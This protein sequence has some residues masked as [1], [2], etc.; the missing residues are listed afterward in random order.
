[1]K[2]IKPIYVFGFLLIVLSLAAFSGQRERVDWR[3]T[4]S[5]DHKIAY[6]A[7]LLY[8]LL[9]SQF[10]ENSLMTARRSFT[11]MTQGN[12]QTGKNYL[13]ITDHLPFGP[14][15]TKRVM[16]HVQE[17][18]HVFASA[19]SFSEDFTDE[20]GFEASL[21]LESLTDT[22]VF[23]NLKELSKT[24]QDTTR[25]NL[26]NPAF[27]KSGGYLY[28]RG[29]IRQSF[30]KLDT[31]LTTVLGEDELGRPNFVR[32]S[33]GEGAFLIHLAP[34]VFTNYHLLQEENYEY[35]SK[36]LSYLPAADVVWDEYYKPYRTGKDS[37]FSAVTDAR[38]LQWAWILMI[39]GLLTFVFSQMKRTQ[40]IIPIENPLENTSLKFARTMG[41]LYFL[42]GNHGDMARKKITHFGD[43]IRNHLYLSVREFTEEEATSVANKT[44][45]P[46]TEIGRL[47]EL[48]RKINTQTSVPE[49]TLITLSR[50]IDEFYQKSKL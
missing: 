29:S 9:P 4:F 44:G 14:A 23:N 10:P 5:K 13:F 41:R 7:F 47:F 24:L 22:G 11:E 28:D 33:H 40:R 26:S 20:L 2:R 32:I 27:H 46:E 36:A 45:I 42:T 17:G 37:V 49:T 8:D 31:S 38:A 6:G 19:E 50:Q 39:A 25:T 30:S 18:G 34:R 12:V 35:A 21:G 15:A 3:K 16:R 1:M 43:Y 48:V